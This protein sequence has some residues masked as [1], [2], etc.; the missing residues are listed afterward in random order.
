MSGLQWKVKQHLHK[1][2]IYTEINPHWEKKFVT[3]IYK[4]RGYV[5]LSIKFI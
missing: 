2:A 1:I 5:C 3:I 4:Y